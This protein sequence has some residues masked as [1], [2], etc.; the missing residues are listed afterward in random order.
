MLGIT[1]V[2]N[3]GSQF[4]QICG[5]EFHK[6]KQERK[7][8][9]T[10]QRVIL[11][12]TSWAHGMTRSRASNSVNK[13]SFLP[14]LICALPKFSGTMWLAPIRVLR[15]RQSSSPGLHWLRGLVRVLDTP[16]I[17]SNSFSQRKACRL[18]GREQVTCST[19][20]SSQA[21]RLSPHT[22]SHQ[23]YR[24]AHPQRHCN[25]IASLPFLLWG[26]CQN[27]LVY[28]DRFPSL[29]GIRVL[30]LMSLLQI[31]FGIS[32][33]YGY[34]PPRALHS[35]RYWDRRS[36]RK[37]THKIHIFFFLGLWLPTCLTFMN[38]GGSLRN[39]FL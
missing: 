25:S 3:Q 31:S 39:L 11:N 16:L 29:L 7:P 23:P 1:V 22:A 33:K 15:R 9:Q 24:K 32:R 12:D 30:V 13:V 20:T 37:H 5:P 4:I 6:K 38:Q 18:E 21:Q 14:S 36:L 26:L 27:Y 17:D 28:L 2:M 35:K 10:D 34:H 19:A 8:A